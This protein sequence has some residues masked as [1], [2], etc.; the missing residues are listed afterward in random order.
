[1][2]SA[3]EIRIGEG[4]DWQKL[5]SYLHDHIPDLKGEMK[6]TQ[7]HG[8]HANLTYLLSFGDSELVIGASEF[9]IWLLE[10]LE[11]TLLFSL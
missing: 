1:M 10:L 7:F 11:T 2:D 4:L 6:V 5:E 3:K 8:G 9:G